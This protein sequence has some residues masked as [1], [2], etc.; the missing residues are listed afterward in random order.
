MDR[1]QVAGKTLGSLV[2]KFGEEI[3]AQVL[4]VVQRD[5]NSSRGIVRQGAYM[6]LSNVL[7]HSS[8]QNVQSNQVLAMLN[9]DFVRKRVWVC[10]FDAV[11]SRRSS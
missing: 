6:C 7:E 3:M 4:P 11:I 9:V 2:V 10:R 8:R 1:R 5:V